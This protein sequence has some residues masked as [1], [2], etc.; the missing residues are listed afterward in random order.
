MDMR[1]FDRE[2]M[3]RVGGVW[4]CERDIP[5]AAELAEMREERK[6]QERAE[7]PGPGDRTPDLPPW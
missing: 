5:D 3:V 4:V 7:R 1:D 6:A 2:D